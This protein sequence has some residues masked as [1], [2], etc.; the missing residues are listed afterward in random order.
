MNTWIKKFVDF[1]GYNEFCGEKKWTEDNGAEWLLDGLVIW[2]IRSIWLREEPGETCS[3]QKNRKSKTR[4]WGK[5]FGVSREIVLLS[6]SSHRGWEANWLKGRMAGDETGEEG[7][8]QTRQ[9][10]L[11]FRKEL[12]F[13]S[14]CNGNVILSVSSYKRILVKFWLIRIEIILN[15]N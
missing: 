14:K 6:H 9:D 2:R 10:H 4:S 15:N 3:R 12:V 11:G 5:N 8:G 7:R 1:I 13:F